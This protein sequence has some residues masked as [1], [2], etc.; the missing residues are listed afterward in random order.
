ML[1]ETKGGSLGCI[2]ISCDND[3]DYNVVNIITAFHFENRFLQGLQTMAT[4]KKGIFLT[5]MGLFI[6]IRNTN[7]KL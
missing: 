5:L 1:I 2:A 6:I 4:N 3:Y 7:G